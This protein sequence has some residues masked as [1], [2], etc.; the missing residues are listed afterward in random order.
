MV[1]VLRIFKARGLPHINLFLYV[2]VQEGT[3]HIHLIQLEPF[4]ATNAK[5][6]LMASRRATGAKV[7]S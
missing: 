7:S 6:I 5:R 2:L 1:G 4:E 3:L